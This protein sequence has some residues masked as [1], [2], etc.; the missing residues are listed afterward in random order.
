[1]A[2]RSLGTLTID[3]VAN[4]GSFISG[5]SKSQ[6]SAEDWRASVVKSASTVSGSITA[7][8]L[9]AASGALALV[10]ATSEH[11]TE[12]DRWAK[13]LGINTQALLQWQYAATK[14]GI[15]G[16]NIADI[17]KDLNDKIG[18]A[19]LN[20]SG[21]AAQALDTLGLSAQKL[22][23]LS[24]DKQLLA[25]S[26]AMQGM[27]TAQKTTIYEALGNDL[28]RLMPLL[29]NGAAGLQK[30]QQAA[31]DKGI[32]PSDED[33]A[34]L[35]AVNQIFQEWEDSFEGFRTRFAVG[36]ASVDLGPLTSSLHSIEDTL[37]SPAVLQGITS[38]ING[39]AQV[40]NLLAG[41]AKY[42]NDLANGWGKTADT[43]QG[44]D[45]DTLI[46]KRKE[47]NESL[48][49]SQ[50]LGGKIDSSFGVIRS[51]K[52]VQAN[53]DKNEALIRTYQA[54]KQ[55]EDIL[56]LNNLDSKG[57]PTLDS[58]KLGPGQTNGKPPKHTVDHSAQR[59]DNSYAS[60]LLQL[61]KQAA[62]IDVVGNKQDKATEL[63]KVNFD[64]E[65]GNLS[66][67]NDAQK[68]QLR[69]AASLVDSLNAQKK[70]HDDNNKAIAY[71]AQLAQQN[72]TTRQGNNNQLLGQGLGSRTR[73]RLQ[74]MTGIRQDF[75]GQQADLTSKYNS[76]DISKSLYDQETKS[77]QDAL[78][79]RLSDQQEYYDE[80]D[81]MRGDW[82]DGVYDS[83]QD[84][85]DNSSDYYQQAADAMT[86]I[87]G[88]ATSTISDN[89]FDV[90]TGAESLG[91]AFKN[92][93]QEI[94]QSVVKA[95]VQM[96]AQWLVNQAIMLTLG[97]T[98]TT[99]GAAQASALSIAWAPAA[100][101]AS[102]ATLGNASIIGAASYD[103]A[104]L[105]STSLA[106]MAHDGIDSVPETGTWLL[107][108]GERVTTAS[109]SAK[110]D[111]T[112][113]RVSTQSGSNMPASNTTVNIPINGNPSDATIALVRQAALEGQRM[114]HAQSVKELNTGTGAMHKAI[115]NNYTAK[116]RAS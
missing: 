3:V 16:D 90:I 100:V 58:L 91:D 105:N 114:G 79:Q 67:L 30:L 14:A 4:T 96:A 9:G 42:A 89:L 44:S 87:L 99:A 102:I 74:E 81:K 88:D 112:L 24:P 17:F 55:A 49:Y 70:A 54:R 29:D 34:K 63:S 23:A 51:T 92:V 39:L 106:G 40:V 15:S 111:A 45:L 36:L 78:Q 86:S 47:L 76:G 80:Q 65:N 12:T 13:S 6:R 104:L 33:I 10:K 72:A 83:L 82:Q 25:I 95:L 77:L 108:K 109:T 94:L 27:N 46:A 56:K 8:M 62:L 60:R 59:L 32:A 93:G 101:S 61:Q 2:N 97:T 53:I 1:M 115:T 69:N 41:A 43:T 5:L 37:T 18:D 31:I 84:Y 19:V 116:R 57:Q 21:E 28:S 103:T 38:M 20:K 85:V 73:G 113:D 22:Q 7:A 48:E 71:A 98:A 35:T 64:I 75:D 68:T 50:T 107:Q 66:K 26:Q 52:E 11:I 110:L